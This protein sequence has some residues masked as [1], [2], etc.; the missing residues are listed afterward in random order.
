MQWGG[1]MKK[2]IINSIPV[3]SRNTVVYATN[4]DEAWEIYWGNKKGKIDHANIG[5]LEFTDFN[6]YVDPEIEEVKEG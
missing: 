1:M 3:M 2:Y 5:D 6:D 4:E